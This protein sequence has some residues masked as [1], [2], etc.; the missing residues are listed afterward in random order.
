[1]KDTIQNATP[2]EIGKVLEMFQILNMVKQTK[3]KS[4]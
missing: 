2:E 1:M 3:S 4:S